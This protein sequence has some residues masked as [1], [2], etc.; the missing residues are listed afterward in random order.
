MYSPTEDPGQLQRQWSALSSLI[1]LGCLWTL[2]LACRAGGPGGQRLSLLLSEPRVPSTAC[3][4]LM[5][6]WKY[7]DK[8]K[9]ATGKVLY[10]PSKTKIGS[11]Y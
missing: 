11:R 10:I 3:T 8:Q 4:G 9:K 2:C 1:P 6:Q 5:I 7:I